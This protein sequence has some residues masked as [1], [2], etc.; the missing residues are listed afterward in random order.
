[1][2]NYLLP[3]TMT[4]RYH[5]LLM[6]V[7]AVAC[8]S[9]KPCTEPLSFVETS[10]GRTVRI[11]PGSCIKRPRLV[12]RVDPIWPEDLR[13]QPG[14]VVLEALIDK[15]GKVSEV[16]VFKSL[17]RV[18]DRNAATAVRQW[19]FE[20]FLVDGEPMPWLTRITVAFRIG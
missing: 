15:G 9:A 10:L 12:K 3:P 17:H 19:E 18:L 14:E 8:S 6:L 20:P 7:V 1:M 13:N 5:W 16:R 11:D 4:F 2:P